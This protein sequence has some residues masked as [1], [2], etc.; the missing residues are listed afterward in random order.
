MLNS[1]YETVQ[2]DVVLTAVY[3]TLG[4]GFT[5]KYRKQL[6]NRWQDNIKKADI[7]CNS[8]FEFQEMF[9]DN[10]K[11]REWREN[12]LP[13]DHYS[14]DNALIMV[15]SKRFIFFID[16]D[17]QAQNWIRK[18]YKT[19][20]RFTKMTDSNFKRTLE[21]GIDLGQ[22]ILVENMSD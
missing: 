5:A 16:P 19:N 10:F 11:I 12:E 21:M 20:I 4:S 1:K 3:I 13:L 15:K 6:I 17:S 2:G 14:T 18:Q 8:V 7:T 9:G 22:L